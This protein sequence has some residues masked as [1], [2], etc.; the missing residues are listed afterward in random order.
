MKKLT[1]NTVTGLAVVALVTGMSANSAE[2]NSKL[3]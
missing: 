1:L 2:A 3:V